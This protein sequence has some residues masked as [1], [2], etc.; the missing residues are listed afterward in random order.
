MESFSLP[1]V[2]PRLDVRPAVR[3]SLVKKSGFGTLHAL[4]YA[5]RELLSSTIMPVSDLHQQSAPLSLR[6]S[7]V[8][9]C[10]FS[11][12]VGRIRPHGRGGVKL[13]VINQPCALTTC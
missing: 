5:K 4:P 10:G 13:N 7:M 12:A 6:V 1:S 3:A 8:W 2:H 11:P 9:V